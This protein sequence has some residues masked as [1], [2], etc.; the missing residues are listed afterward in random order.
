VHTKR[1]RG[2]RYTNQKREVLQWGGIGE[3]TERNFRFHKGSEEITKVGKE[4]RQRRKEN[5][6]KWKGGRERRG[7]PFS[8]LGTQS[9]V[10]RKSE[11]MALG[12]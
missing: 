5:L 2:I 7:T 6:K 1:T 12:D 4:R 11:K 8:V 10:R 3:E 9:R